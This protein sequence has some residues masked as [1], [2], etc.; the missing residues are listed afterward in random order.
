MC[1]CM[2]NHLFV[3]FATSDCASSCVFEYRVRNFASYYDA[4]WR[5]EA[6]YG[7]SSG[8][9]IAKLKRSCRR[10]DGQADFQTWL[11]KIGT[12]SGIFFKWLWTLVLTLCARSDD[13]KT[14]SSKCNDGRYNCFVRATV[15]ASVVQYF[16]YIFEMRISNNINLMY[17]VSQSQI[18]PGLSCICIWSRWWVCFVLQT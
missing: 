15:A 18:H 16:K 2:G 1:W 7:R 17:F 8:L 9:K 3:I 4:E 6:V 10:C 12:K 14:R 11:V 13:C 5:K